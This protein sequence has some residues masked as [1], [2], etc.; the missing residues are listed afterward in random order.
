MSEPEQEPVVAAIGIPMTP[1]RRVRA[2]RW[3][4]QRAKHLEPEEKKLHECRGV[5]KDK[6]F[7]LFKELVDLASRTCN[8]VS[9]MRALAGWKC[10]RFHGYNLTGVDAILRSRDA[11][12]AAHIL[13]YMTSGKMRRITFWQEINYVYTLGMEIYNSWGQ[14]AQR[15]SSSLVFPCLPVLF[16]PS[17]G[18]ALLVSGTI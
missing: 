12:L 14:E 10:Q 8:M 1:E 16:C 4:K 15:E 9:G 3:I 2:L 7:L 13:A 5:V 17:L 18:L 6:K 11:G